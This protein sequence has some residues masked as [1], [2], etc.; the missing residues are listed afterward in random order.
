MDYWTSIMNGISYM[1][2]FTTT[3]PCPPLYSPD[4]D[5]ARKLAETVKHTGITLLA[6]MLTLASPA[7]EAAF[8]VDNLDFGHYAGGHGWNG[9]WTESNPANPDPG[10]TCDAVDG[11]GPGDR[12][13]IHDETREMRLHGA[14]GN[15]PFVYREVDLSDP[16]IAGATLR[17]FVDTSRNLGANDAMTV[18][19]SADGGSSWTPLAVYENDV[20]SVERLDI[21][22]HL[23]ANMRIRFQVTGDTNVDGEYFLI[24]SVRILGRVEPAAPAAGSVAWDWFDGDSFSGGD[25][26]IDDWTENDDD[27]L[28]TSG[29][30]FTSGGRLHL[31]GDGD[32]QPSYVSRT[33]NLT[34]HANAIIMFDLDVAG[35]LSQY[36]DED[37]ME[38][39]TRASPS[40]P[41]TQVRQFNATAPVRDRLPR[42]NHVVEIPAEDLSATTGI[43]FAVAGESTSLAEPGEAF[44]IDNVRIYPMPVK[45]DFA[46]DELVGGTPLHNGNTGPSQVFD[47]NN[48]PYADDGITITLSETTHGPIMLF[49]SL[50]PTGDDGD[51]GSPNPLVSVGESCGPGDPTIFGDYGVIGG[52]GENCTPLGNLLII[53][54]DGDV[55][56][57]NDSPLGGLISYA[58]DR[59]V[60]FTAIMFIDD[61][62][63]LNDDNPSITLHL[64]GGT[65]ITTPFYAFNDYGGNGANGKHWAT[66]TDFQADAPIAGVTGIDIHLQDTSGGTQAFFITEPGIDFGDAPDSYGT[67]LASDGP[68]HLIDSYRDV[69]IGF[70]VDSEQDGQPTVGSDGDDAFTAGAL[71]DEDGVSLPASSSADGD[72]DDTVYT[73]TVFATNDTGDDAL[74]CAWMDFD[75]DGAFDNTPNTSTTTA[76][77]DTASGTDDGERSC[78]LVPAGTV[79]QSFSVSWTI[80]EAERDNTGQFQFR[81]RL[82]TDSSFTAS[83]TALGQASDGEV[84]DILVSIDTVPVTLGHFESRLAGGRL[85]VEW[86]TMSETFNAGFNLWAQVAGEWLP[87]TGRP[88]LSNSRDAVSV[89]RYRTNV[90]LAG[91]DAGAVDAIALS[92]IETFGDGEMYGPFEI[93]VVY[94]ES[95]RPAPIPWRDIRAGVDRRMAV[96]G[97]RP[98]KR[99][100]RKSL[101]ATVDMAAGHLDVAVAN[102][103]MQRLTYEQMAAAGFDLDGASAES[104][105]VTLKGEPVA[106]YVHSD[107]G[108]FGPGGYL[109]FWG[110]RPQLPD[111]LYVEEYTYRIALDADR[112]RVHDDAAR[113]AADGVDVALRRIDIDED[114]DYHFVNP[115]PDP[116]YAALLRHPWG[117]AEWSVDVAV[118]DDLV[119]D[120]AGRIEVTVGGL[121]DFGDVAP[122]HRV[123][124]TV[125]GQTIDEAGFDGNNARR[126]TAELPAGLLTPGSNRVE[127]SLPGNTGA[128]FD[129][130]FVDRVS[131]W[132][133]HRLAARDGRV[134]VDDAA[135]A[136]ELSANGFSTR[137][138]IAYAHQ[139]DGRL[140]RLPVTLRPEQGGGGKASTRGWRASVA[141]IEGSGQDTEYWISVEDAV[142]SPAVVGTG[143]TRSLLPGDPD[144]LVIAH[145]AFL[146][147]SESEPH[148]LNDYVEHR[149]SQG[150]RV[151]AVSIADIQDTYGGGM[152]L[153]GA[154][155]A[156]LADAAAATS[157]THVLLVGGDSYDYR[158]RL[159]LGSLSF[160]PTLYGRSGQ[161]AHAPLDD[162]LVDLD[163]DGRGDK[164]VGRWPVRTVDDLAS[165]VRKTL[166]FEAFPGG[167]AHRNS[168]LWVADSKDPALPSFAGQAERMIE[169]LVS[170]GAGGTVEPW[171]TDHISRVYFDEVTA[172][173][174]KSIAESA[175]SMLLDAIAGGPT[176]TGF[177]G[178]GSPTSW[179]FQGLLHPRHV[180][181]MDNEGRPTL[182]MTLTCYTSYFVSPYADTLANRLL[183]G[184]R[185]DAGGNRVAAAANGAVAVHGAA[186][187]SSFINNEAV[188]AEVLTRQLVDG[189]T[190]GEAIRKVR[191]GKAGAAAG[192]WTLLGD[193]T[194][195]VGGR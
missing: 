188:A 143:S 128:A 183:N 105:A 56:D 14:N 60:V 152:P 106:R 90:S 39:H 104:I 163:G 142:L 19:V 31:H 54:E 63:P 85:G 135:G 52:P 155:T 32:T 67:T 127:V 187:L 102:P 28:P 87:L 129:M 70:E 116:W 40:D 15:N 61:I 193:P 121:T 65:S 20:Q 141:A 140:T 55:N 79:E 111:A 4:D 103:G 118:G 27:G 189:D 8:A 150:W 194:L 166:D 50:N 148:P 43:R 23:S 161:V 29:N 124:L 173:P 184:Y 16:T 80:P 114:N 53:S 13:C 130:V 171:P 25:G 26:W 91:L 164:A 119:A 5:G 35:D 133:P 99:G 169:R 191:H 172:Q 178:H 76:D 122:D 24:D 157:Y 185:V 176:I 47:E 192:S 156:F 81:F 41:W 158:D 7:A 88:I 33:V 44:V 89:Q 42:N 69:R 149:R 59:E 182:I 179:T 174:G 75:Q 136:S 92:T 38:I 77:P 137:R 6:L 123:A 117:P 68:R 159:G 86:T 22:A 138:V 37:E 64:A 93:G 83:P 96:L 98:G 48:Q 139:A 144:L 49:D 115:L 12:I 58:F 181:Q 180:A 162:R 11:A 9:D 10:P 126:I 21:T 82:T 36:E 74:L 177:A 2:H 84:E 110:E 134:H 97:Y 109:E 195:T 34:G 46:T 145:P 73:A 57:P 170:P 153:P 175:R 101:A 94:G 66:F 131:L 45:L 112:V 72:G 154:L 18:S 3:A 120:T 190:L 160:I 30:L 151:T 125:N 165:I 167:P 146:P 108:R 17:F 51:L 107:G 95:S 78:V 186:T 1:D 113:T 147:A 132:Y 62:R 100:W 71:D 168:A